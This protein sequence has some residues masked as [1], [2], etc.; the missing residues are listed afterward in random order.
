[1]SVTFDTFLSLTSQ[2]AKFEVSSSDSAW[3][4]LIDQAL[5]NDKVKQTESINKESAEVNDNTD[6]DAVVNSAKPLKE[7]NTN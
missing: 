1:M 7:N 2:E 5:K 4:N 6:T 3:G